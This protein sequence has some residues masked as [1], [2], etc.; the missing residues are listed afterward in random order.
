MT[1]VRADAIDC[2][3]GCVGNLSG[4]VSLG[5]QHDD[6]S[7]EVKGSGSYGNEGRPR[8]RNV[9]NVLIV[10]SGRRDTREHFE[11]MPEVR[12]WVWMTCNRKQTSAL[13]PALPAGKERC[14]GKFS[15]D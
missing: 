5:S 6:L 2:Q 15:V 12:D 9:C 3:F 1:S 11:D 8:A 10:G 13:K 4:T 14:D 7:E